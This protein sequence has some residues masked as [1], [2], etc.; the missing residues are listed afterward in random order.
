[1]SDPKLVLEILS[2]IERGIETR[3]AAFLK[4]RFG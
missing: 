1:M 4:S 2:Q 3:Y